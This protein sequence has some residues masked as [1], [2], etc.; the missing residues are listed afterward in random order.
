MSGVGQGTWTREDTTYEWYPDGRPSVTGVHSG[1]GF[2]FVIFR[3]P[4]PPS[5]TPVVQPS[6]L[7]DKDLRSYRNGRNFRVGEHRE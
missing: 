5:R 3:V 6:Q 2:L 7:P 1:S 4:V